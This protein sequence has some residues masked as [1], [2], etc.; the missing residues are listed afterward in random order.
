MLLSPDDRPAFRHL[1]LQYAKKPRPA[2][3]CPCWSGKPLDKCHR[4]K[5][6]SGESYPTYFRCICG[7]GRPYSVCSCSKR[8]MQISERYREEEH[9]IV[10]Q[11]DRDVPFHPSILGER[12][13]LK[14]DPVSRAMM[15]LLEGLYPLLGVERPTTPEAIAKHEEGLQRIRKMADELVVKGEVDPAYAYALHRAPFSPR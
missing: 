1:V 12:Y 13:P 6:G 2:R 8:S 3:I 5:T 9:R 7:S 10:A 15:E 4:K 14:T 11:F